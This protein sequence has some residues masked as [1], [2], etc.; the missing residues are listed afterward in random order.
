MGEAALPSVR[1]GYY[2]PQE[3]TAVGSMQG[4]SDESPPSAHER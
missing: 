3:S 1:D 2:E 4:I